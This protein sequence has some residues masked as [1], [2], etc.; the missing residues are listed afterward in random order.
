MNDSPYIEMQRAVDIIQ[1]SKHATNKIAATL[2][3][4][5][6]DGKSFSISKTNYWPELI[7]SHIGHDTRIG[8]SSGTIHSEVACILAAPLTKDAS[9]CVTDPFCPNCAKNMAE[10][11][12]RN[13]YIDHKGFSKDFARR[14][15][16]SFEGMSMQI[17]ARA[18]INVYE[19]WREKERIVPILEVDKTYLPPQDNPAEVEPLNKL[20][21]ADLIKTKEKKYYGRSYAI[22]IAENTDG[23]KYSL[24]ARAHPAIGYSMDKDREEIR[25]PDSKYSYMLEPINRLL[26]NAPRA[27]LSII[28]GQLYCSQ[29]PTS[30]EQVNLVG[31]GITKIHIGDKTKARDAHALKAAQ[32]LSEH[33]IIEIIN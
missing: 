2:F 15:G 30:R 26:M 18:G 22:A 19:L 12:I 16:S 5:D 27:G 8:N 25:Y 14:R 33:H 10:A 29:V 11:G 3:G 1:Q 21:L 7:Q 9:L 17:C 24:T 32:Q 20:S 23:E 13:I 28:D 6:S 4:T 31:A